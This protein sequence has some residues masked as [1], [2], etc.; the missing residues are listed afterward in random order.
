L[1]DTK[2]S[3]GS[4]ITAEDVAFSLLRMRD[5]PEAAYSASP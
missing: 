1:R 3:D 2:L 4:P 5:D